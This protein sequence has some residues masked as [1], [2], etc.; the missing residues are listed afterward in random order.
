MELGEEVEEEEE[1]R[2][3][4]S[5]SGPDETSPMEDRCVMAAVAWLPGAWDGQDRVGLLCPGAS[6]GC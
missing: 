1:L 3:G 6:P 2:G 5:E 4:G